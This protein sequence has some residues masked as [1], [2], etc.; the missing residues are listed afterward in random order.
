MLVEGQGGHGHH[1]VHV[2]LHAEHGDEGRELGVFLH[3]G[4]DAHLGRNALDGRRRD[5]VRV[6]VREVLAI[7]LGSGRTCMMMEM[8]P[9]AAIGTKNHAIAIA[10]SPKLGAS[11]SEMRMRIGRRP[12]P[13]ASR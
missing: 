4:D 8:L 13:P 5:V 12:L 6:V 9:I 2:A 7:S 3:E 10:S 1:H 11:A